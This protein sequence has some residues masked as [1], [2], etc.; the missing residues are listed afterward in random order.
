MIR[1]K[2]SIVVQQNR[3]I[4]SFFNRNLDVFARPFDGVPAAVDPP[5]RVFTVQQT[6]GE[7]D[8]L[9]I[10]GYLTT[11]DVPPCP[12][13]PGEDCYTTSGIG[14][15]FG[16]DRWTLGSWP[17]TY[18]FLI[19]GSQGMTFTPVDYSSTASVY[20]P[21]N[22]ATFP[23]TGSIMY[24]FSGGGEEASVNSAVILGWGN[25]ADPLTQSPQV[26]IGISER[27]SGGAGD[28]P[29]GTKHLRVDSVNGNFL[30]NDEL[31]WVVPG[32]LGQ[33]YPYTFKVVWENYTVGSNR[34]I[35]F[36]VWEVNT[37][38]PNDW[39]WDSSAPVS[40]EP[41]YFGLEFSTTSPSNTTLAF[42]LDFTGCAILPGNQDCSGQMVE[43]NLL[44]SS[45]DWVSNVGVKYF[46]D[47]WYDGLKAVKGVDYTETENGIT[48]IGTLDESTIVKAR[49]VAL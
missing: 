43:M 7:V 15:D 19:I 35:R 8:P 42:N 20:T 10:S 40:Q 6:S 16:P 23:W 37:A 18:D 38:E 27:I 3:S 29:I 14:C 39:F 25:L 17:D 21:I 49:F 12:S 32:T 46:T 28:I 34:R 45:G 47:V 11:D 26:S 30:G 5:S 33:S 4:T 1:K 22:G 44:F 31:E 24:N 9:D 48:P 13:I 2:N 36:K 41:A